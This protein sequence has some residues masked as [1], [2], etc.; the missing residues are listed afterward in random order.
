MEKGELTREIIS[1]AIEVHRNL[2]PGLLE[3]VYEECLCREL[4]KAGFTF[5]R[6]RELPVQYKG[7]ALD[8]LYRMDL[9]VAGEVVVE[10]KAIEAVLKVHEAQLLTYMKLSGIG[11][12]LLLNFNVAMMRDG[13]RR[14][15]R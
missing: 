4:S 11:V 5:E 14:F 15:I 12:G 2:G 1:S 3:S 13:I 8:Y 9:V 10:I 7:Q 6:Q